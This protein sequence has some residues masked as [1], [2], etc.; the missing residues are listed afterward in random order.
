MSSCRSEKRIYVLYRVGDGDVKE[1][2]G[3]YDSLGEVICAFEA[4]REKED[5]I[6]LEIRT[7]AAG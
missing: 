4:E 7:E 6:R 3:W 1:P 5:G 2:I